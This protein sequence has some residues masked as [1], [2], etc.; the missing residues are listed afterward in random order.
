MKKLMALV[1]MMLLLVTAV[2]HADDTEKLD[3]KRWLW[4]SA[5]TEYSLWIDKESVDKQTVDNVEILKS[6]TRVHRSSDDMVLLAD[7][8]FKGANEARVTKTLVYNNQGQLVET[9]DTQDAA[10]IPIAQGSMDAQVYRSTYAETQRN[11]WYR[12]PFD[13]GEKPTNPFISPKR[14][15]IINRKAVQ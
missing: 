9:L 7:W 11:S 14:V 1:F 5:D 13:D 4:V 8:E 10:F 12:K 6:T 3:Q 2:C 15:R